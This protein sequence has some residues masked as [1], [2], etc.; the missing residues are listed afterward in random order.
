MLPTAGLYLPET[1]HRKS[2]SATTHTEAEPTRLKYFQWKNGRQKHG[3]RGSEDNIV[4][5]PTRQ[6]SEDSVNVLSSLP[7]AFSFA[8]FVSSSNKAS[9][10]TVSFANLIQGVR[11]DIAEA[12]RLYLS[13]AVSTFLDAW[14][15]KR[16]WVERILLDVR[17]TLNDIGMD[18]D[19]VRVNGDE[20]APFAMKRKFEWL[21]THQ[22]RLIKKQEQL[23]T[24][25]RDLAGAIHV[26]QTAEM[27]GLPGG[28]LHDPIYEAPVRPWVPTTDRNVLRGPYSRQRG[29]LNHATASDSS[30]ALYEAE[31]ECTRSS[32]IDS[33]LAELPG[34]TPED[35]DNANKLDI[36]APSN[37]RRPGDASLSRPSTLGSPQSYPS[38]VLSFSPPDIRPDEH[39]DG[40]TALS[41]LAETSIDR[42]DS[43][44]STKTTITVPRIARR[45]RAQAI[46][47][48]RHSQR[49]RSL[50]SEL[51]HLK[52]QSSL[53]EDLVGWVLPSSTSDRLQSHGWK[54][55]SVWSSPT[56][57]VTSSPAIAQVPTQNQLAISKPDSG[58]AESTNRSPGEQCDSGIENLSEPPND[59]GNASTQD[60]HVPDTLSSTDSIGCSAS[61]GTSLHRPERT[62][63]TQ[64]SNSF[65]TRKPLLQAAVVAGSTTELTEAALNRFTSLTARDQRS[66]PLSPVA[67]NH[68]A[69]L[70]LLQQ[71]L[72]SQTY[73]VEKPKLPTPFS[74]FPEELK[75]PKSLHSI[76]EYSKQPQAKTE[77]EVTI[78]SSDSIVSLGVHKPMSA[79]AKRQAAH[80]RRMER[81]HGK[82]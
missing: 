17:H 54:N 53:I 49:H 59:N 8:D 12:S 38:P 73:V 31:R 71:R 74:T 11:Q 5:L 48:P 26:M 56:N 4:A 25:Q 34:S 42:N 33:P 13:P 18:M 64:S 20:E 77:E 3:P 28:L 21:L 39:M 68:D 63:S 16:T 62:A 36:Y 78:R 67:L 82:L 24:C 44:A 43:T 46:D 75:S 58:I 47:V 27:C 30:V 29:R 50:P 80:R 81:A 55:S 76:P 79:Q 40:S 23:K 41:S 51:P 19:A 6:T 32:S 15:D 37:L 45:Y 70:S 7:T 57:S 14:P 35:L 72:L 10:E 66:P 60:H 22:K 52:S 2:D 61:T 9:L 69:E 65:V 1:L